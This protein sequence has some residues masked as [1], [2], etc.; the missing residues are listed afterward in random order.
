MLIKT[1]ETQESRKIQM[2]STL[3]LHHIAKILQTSQLQGLCLR[4]SYAHQTLRR[5]MEEENDY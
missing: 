2:N 5:R 3:T 4:Q 1:Q